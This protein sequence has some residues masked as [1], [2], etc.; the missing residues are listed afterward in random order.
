MLFAMAASIGGAIARDR[1]EEQLKQTSTELRA[2]FQ[3]L[4]DDYFRLGADKSILDYK[5]DRGDLYLN[6]DNFMGKW[7]AGLLP[8]KVETQFDKAIT[9][10]QR[11]QKLMTIEYMSP[12]SHGKR[13]YEEVRLLPFLNQQ[14]IVVSRDITDRK[15]AEE[16]LR[17]HR[18]HLE[19]LVEART[20]ELT[21]ANIRLQKEIIKR[22]QTEEV[23][24]EL[25]QKLEDASRH[26]SNFLANMS[27]ELRTPLNAMIGYTSLTLNAL[28]E[29]LAPKHLQNLTKAEQSARVLLQLINDV[30]DFSKIEAGKMDIFLE[31][32]ALNEILDDVVVIA[33]GLLLNKAVDL[34]AQIAP[35]LPLVHSDFTKLKQI[36]NNL[37]GNA[38]KFTQL[39]FVAVRAR[40]VEQN[41]AIF[42]EIEDSGAGIPE[43]KLEHIFE[44]FKQVDGSISK[45]FGGSG[46]G[47]A[48]TKKFCELLGIDINVRSQEGKGTA[49]YLRIPVQASI[50]AAEYNI[51]SRAAEQ[52]EDSETT[53]EM[54]LL[55][56]LPEEYSS[57]L[58]IDDD[59]MNLSLIS[60]I[61]SEAG[62]RVYEVTTGEEGITLARQQHP[63]IILMDLVLPGIDGFETT[64]RLCGDAATASIPII[65]CS[66][67]ATKEFHEQARQAGCIGYITKPIEPER[68]ITQVRQYIA[69]HRPTRPQ[70]A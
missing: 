51:P 41:R 45:K 30:L 16:E 57:I 3:A 61:F 52:T 25:N 55:T 56:Q 13:R 19:D 1:T 23:L 26:K 59:E 62:Y 11:T 21:K 4:P 22:Q 37:L 24:R 8:E 54:T 33:E 34:Q 39:G 10:V 5:M 7:A 15:E 63:D 68:L 44:S 31:T 65:A 38:V 18:D 69:T 17:Q 50:A 70:P 20:S 49:F 35:E 47:L 9:H 32:I 64:R 67:V 66:A 53:D 58:I 12:T 46:L 29:E 43:D 28:R 60:E 42:V 6:S 14:V 40:S 36:L 2:L 27:H 48:I